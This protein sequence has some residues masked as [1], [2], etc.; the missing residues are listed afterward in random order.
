MP[1][2]GRKLLVS[3]RIPEGRGRMSQSWKALERDGARLI[4][5]RRY[6]ASSGGPIDAESSQF[7]LDAKY[8]GRITVPDLERWAVAIAAAGT[9]RGKVGVL[10]VKRKAG[11]GR[12][13]PALMILT[14]AAWSELTLEPHRPS[15]ASVMQQRPQPEP[16]GMT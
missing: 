4:R 7:V 16:R 2:A 8:R 1:A 5:D 9:A 3:R 15:S 14:E 13:T 12:P 11:A 6:P 10:L